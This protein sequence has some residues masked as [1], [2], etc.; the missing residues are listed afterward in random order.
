MHERKTWHNSRW[1]WIHWSIDYRVHNI[2]TVRLYY[3]ELGVG[4]FSNM[5]RRYPRCSV[6]GGADYYG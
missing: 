3:M 1:D 5:D 6:I 4:A 2:E